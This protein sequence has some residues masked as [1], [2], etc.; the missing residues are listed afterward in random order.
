MI[1]PSP[2]ARS[3]TSHLQPLAL[4]LCRPCAPKKP[5]CMVTL[6]SQ[7]GQKFEVKKSVIKQSEL[8]LTLIEE[9]ADQAQD[10]S[11]PSPLLFMYDASTSTY[12]Y[13]ECICLCSTIQI[14][15]HFGG[16]GGGG[17]FYR[18]SHH[19]FSSLTCFSSSGVKSFVML[20]VWRISS[21]VF[22]LIIEAT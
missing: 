6:C 14:I 16:V 21:A 8:V 3:I 20:K 22:P 15:H 7:E 17:A 10:H 13:F 4:L 11:S 2:L 9:D 1:F 19:L 12:Y 5:W 18:S